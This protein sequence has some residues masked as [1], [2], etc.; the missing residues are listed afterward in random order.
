[1]GNNKNVMRWE[2][3]YSKDEEPDKMGRW[4]RKCFYKSLHIAWVNRL[5]IKDMIRFSVNTQFPVNGNDMP[6]YCGHFETFK[7]AKECVEYCWEKFIS[8]CR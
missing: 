5:Q 7:E 3:R 1:M 4:A 6:Q 2:C 8:V